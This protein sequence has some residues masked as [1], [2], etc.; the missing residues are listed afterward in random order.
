ML[1]F[2]CQLGFQNIVEMLQL[3]GSAL[4]ELMYVNVLRYPGL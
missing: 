3:E 4:K 1:K 2:R